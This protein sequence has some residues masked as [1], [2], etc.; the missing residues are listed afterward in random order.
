MSAWEKE[1]SEIKKELASSLKSEKE[2]NK[3]VVFGSFLHSE[4]PGDI[5]VAVFQDSDESYLDLA[6]KYR[7]LTR[8]VSRRIAVDIIP[9]KPAARAHSFLS[10]IESGE[11][12][13]ER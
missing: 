6:M 11:L 5:D 1:K 9:I 10:E 2:I 8:G 7:R 4:N 13:Y 3:I 12:I